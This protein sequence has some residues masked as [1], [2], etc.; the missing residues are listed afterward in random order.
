[1]APGDN[2]AVRVSPRAGVSIENF[3]AVAPAI[4]KDYPSFRTGI[5]AQ[6]WEPFGEIIPRPFPAFAR[7]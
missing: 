1:M 5:Q 6:C 4:R 2:Y 7:M 3:E